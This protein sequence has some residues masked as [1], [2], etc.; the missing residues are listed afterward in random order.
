MKIKNCTDYLLNDNLIVNIKDFVYN[1]LKIWKL[2]FKGVLSLNIYYIKYIPT[3][4]SDRV[5][6]DRIDNNEDY[7]YLFIDVNRYIEENCGIKYLL[8]ASTYTNK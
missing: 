6:I 4:S 5:S 8:F 3:Q 7:L 1:L 2:S